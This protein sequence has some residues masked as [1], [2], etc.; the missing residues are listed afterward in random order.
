MST[1]TN[2]SNSESREFHP[3]I[4]FE[5][6]FNLGSMDV[7][8]GGNFEDVIGW[9]PI[10]LWSGLPKGVFD[11]ILVILPPPIATELVHQSVIDALKYGIKMHTSM[12]PTESQI[13]SMENAITIINCSSLDA[14]SLIDLVKNNGF[15]KII[16]IPE[17]N[18]YRDNNIPARPITGL[19]LVFTSQDIW[20]QHV[21]S[22]CQ[23][24]M[25]EIKNHNSYAVVHVDDSCVLSIKNNEA[26]CSIDE[27]YVTCLS[28]KNDK[29]SIV[30][31]YAQRWVT[32]I[33]GGM[34]RE[35]ESEL[36][37]LNLPETNRLH[38]LAQLNSRA[39][40][41]E[42][43]NRILN[44][45]IDHYDDWNK[46]TLVQL[47][48]IAY[49]AD[50]EKLTN[51]FLPKD[52]AGL[53]AQNWLE[54]ALD[55]AM[56]ICNNSLIEVYDIAMERLFPNSESLRENRDRRLLMNCQLYLKQRDKLFTTVGFRDYHLTIQTEI[57][58]DYPNY[59][60]I[61]GTANSWGREWAELAA[62]CC[63]THA[64][65]VGKPRDAADVA[66]LLT[67]SYL[68]GRQ[69]TQ[70][71]L[72]SMRK[73]VLN[74][75]IPP[76]EYD[77]YSTL[78][79]SIIHY[80]AH[81]PNDDL[82]RTRI[83]EFLSVESCGKIGIPAITL[84]LLDIA[85]RQ[86]HEISNLSENQ[87][88]N[89]IESYEDENFG[90]TKLEDDLQKALT[91]LDEQHVIEYGVT[92][93]PSGMVE[94]P[95]N[96]I[97]LVC[98][99]INFSAPKKEDVDL[100]FMEKL[101]SLV[102]ALAPHAKNE[103]NTDLKVLRLLGGHQAISFRYQ[104][105]RNLAEQALLLGLRNTERKRLSWLAYADIYQRCKDPLQALY[106]LAC[107][108]A[109]KGPTTP[110]DLWQEIFTAS[111]ILRDLGL[112][113]QARNLLPL[114]SKLMTSLGIDP[115]YDPRIISLE[116]SINFS[117]SESQ[118]PVIIT[119]MM[120]R[121]TYS[122][123]NAL[124][125]RSAL[126][127]LIVLLS[128]A[129][130]QALH[131]QII[132]P[133]QTQNILNRGLELLGENVAEFIS[134]VAENEPTAVAITR[135]FN[136]IERS[137]YSSDVPNDYAVI[138]VAARR[139]LNS[140]TDAPRKASENALAIEI[141]ADHAVSMVPRSVPLEHDWP[142]QYAYSLNALGADVVFLGLDTTGEL[143][144]VH[145]SEKNIYRV[146]QPGYLTTFKDRMLTWLETYPHRYG[147]IDTADGN[148]EFFAAMESL[149]I[150]LPLAR[151]LLV[152][153]EPEL[154]QLT[155]N[156]SLVKIETDGMQDFIGYHSE[157]A[158]APS[159]S[160]LAIIHEN[161]HLN[162]HL[163]KA[164][165]SYQEGTEGGTMGAALQRLEGTFKDFG[166]SLDTVQK[167]PDLR[168]AEISIIVAHGDL[169]TGGRYIHRI[170]D[171]DTLVE[172]P[173]SVANALADSDVVIL[174]V[175]SG[176]RIDKN[177]WSNTTVGLPKLLLKKGVRAVIASPWPLD[178]KV[179]YN[180]LEPFL[181]EWDA[182][183]S[184]FEATKKANDIIGVNLG[185]SPQYAL[186]MTVY[187]DAF[188]RKK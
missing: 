37:S 167:L 187:G 87:H 125:D 8:Q 7:V 79:K 148:N 164:W 145:V 101:V 65:L 34:V 119:K 171:E 45:C 97:R 144:V 50:N 182:G 176:G 127:P 147:I 38:L 53:A 94:D 95:D 74:D 141:L 111:R 165:I 35:V 14:Q 49:Q 26:I 138:S 131:F 184:L 143:V 146:K 130:Q 58:S 135:Q 86:I 16:A 90:G 117:A 47:A 155:F 128:Q 75:I 76:E 104:Q 114:L 52:V 62:I 169:M 129:V 149:D 61:V 6:G 39:K 21:V 180:W 2:T 106:A 96:L 142:E 15:K 81:Y 102:C 103:I 84:T 24:I 118:D 159:L 25:S 133:T 48:S 126:M 152:I 92:I 99:L 72:T 156:L 122:C 140:P 33:M 162:K 59:S 36:E 108:F 89:N 134:T 83:I 66:K 157:I 158:M 22:I 154:Q 18:K 11:G 29:K 173:N 68:Y 60:E 188:L 120:D 4:L 80:L 168:N 91:W 51:L 20:I 64:N 109:T 9:I 112:L 82:T 17:I 107:A 78:L 174:F 115:E 183:A 56:D 139:L 132:I 150:R 170:S 10:A 113:D 85:N 179:S 121:L 124:D 73:M 88:E 57:F 136:L 185:R 161:R 54:K 27:C 137:S 19:S 77:Y 63:C 98:R 5:S 12:D 30:D 23:Q 70:I 43:T 71:L 110:S 105:A 44:I 67:N 32:Q 13:S 178:V 163:R 46:E 31:Q 177:P 172:S 175:C 69:A 28:F 40:N 153:A 181:T 42:E 100:K 160:W 1:F 55:L 3:K 123:E 116:E 151:K 166:F 41:D 186:A 93:L